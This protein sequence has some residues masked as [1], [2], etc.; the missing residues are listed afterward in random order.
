MD[1]IEPRLTFCLAEHPVS[2]THK[3]SGE[4]HFMLFEA[5]TLLQNSSG[6]HLK[7]P[8]RCD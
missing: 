2:H 7:F 1:Q 5:A 3:K 4:W 8:A 6:Q